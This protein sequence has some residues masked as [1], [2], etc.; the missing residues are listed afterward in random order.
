M[1]LIMLTLSAF[2]SCIESEFPKPDQ[3]FLEDE[4]HDKDGD[5]FTENTGDCDDADEIVA[6]Q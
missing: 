6:S 3:R 4:N 1:W 2:F 5:G